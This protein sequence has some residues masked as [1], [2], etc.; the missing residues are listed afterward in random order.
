MEINAPSHWRCVDF[1][2]DIHLDAAEPLTY[3]L[4]SSYMANTRADAIFILGDLFEVWVGDDVLA[5]PDSFEQS[6]VATLH[7]AAQRA[8]LYVMVGN[9]DFLMGPRLM[10]QCGATALTDPCTLQFGGQ[11]FALSHGDALCIDDIDYQTFRTL[12]R[13]PAWQKEFLAKP[14]QERQAIAKSIRAQSESKKRS[15]IDYAD[16]NPQAASQLLVGLQAN[17]LIHGHTHKP[18]TVS[19]ADGRKRLVLS[20]WVAQASPARADVIR[21]RLDD[22]GNFS[23]SRLSPEAIARAGD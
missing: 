23:V 20:D 22:A 6:A 13:S 10:A 16:V 9:R 3:A 8:A 5:T 2:S 7:C 21:L 18:G 15:A 17:T 14:L 19:L 1:L 11:R 12:V 4:W